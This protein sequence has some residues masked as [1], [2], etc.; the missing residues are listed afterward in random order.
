MHISHNDKDIKKQV[1]AKSKDVKIFIKVVL[2]HVF[3][4]LVSYLLSQVMYM[5]SSTYDEVKFTISPL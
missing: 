3:L 5:C 4:S 1:A 2:C